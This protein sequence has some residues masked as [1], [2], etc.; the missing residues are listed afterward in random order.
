MIRR[1]LFASDAVVISYAIVLSIVALSFNIAD[2]YI[3]ISF[4]AAV[5]LLTLLLS[6][7]Y[8]KYCG[9][10]WS[11]LKYWS[12]ILFVLAAYRENFYFVPRVTPFEP[13]YRFDHI[14]ADID[15]YFAAVKSSIDCIGNYLVTDLLTFCYWMYF[16]MPIILG[17][18]LYSKG[19]LKEFRCGMSGL[20][21]AWFLSYIGYL[22]IPAMGPYYFIN[23]GDY[24]YLS[25]YVLGDL[26][27]NVMYTIQWGTADAFPSGH[28]LITLMTLAYSFKYHRKTFLFL[29]PIGS[30]LIVATIYLKYHYVVDVLASFVLFPII[31]IFAEFLNGYFENDYGVNPSFSKSK[32]S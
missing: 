31:F 11:F 26:M 23:R 18:V 10:F 25:G 3:F 29:A 6:Y 12:I 8:N 20:M 13:D 22:I 5:V 27:S 19:L 15:I 16:P 24:P 7:S 32:R 1:W 14:L 30:G 4:H 21:M 9:R 28:T 17:T 2:K